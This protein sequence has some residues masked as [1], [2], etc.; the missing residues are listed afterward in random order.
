M[1]F[2]YSE[3]LKYYFQIRGGFSTSC[4][5]ILFLYHTVDYVYSM[6][7]RAMHGV[8][9]ETAKKFSSIPIVSKSLILTAA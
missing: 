7:R 3:Y 4:G 8:G 2:L 6:I 5:F 1:F 9:G